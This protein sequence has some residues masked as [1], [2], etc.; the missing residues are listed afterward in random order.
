ME[1][2]KQFFNLYNFYGAKM[3]IKGSL[4]VSTFMLKWFSV[5][6]NCPVKIGPKMA[7]F[8]NLSV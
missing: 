8:G 3:T 1:V 5:A 4:Y 6:K 2:P 7:V